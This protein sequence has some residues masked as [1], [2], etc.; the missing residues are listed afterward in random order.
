MRCQEIEEMLSAYANNE[1]TPDQQEAVETHLAGCADCRAKLEDYRQVRQQLE[2]L[3]TVPAAPDIKEIMLSRIKSA[4]H[5]E[6]SLKTWGRRALVLVP[7]AAVLAA[8]LVLQPWSSLNGIHSTLAK[9]HAAIESVQSYRFS[10]T[11]S[12]DIGG[13]TLKMEAEFMAPDSYHFKENADGTDMESTLIGDK[14]Y[15]K[16]DDVSLYALKS[17]INSFSSMISKDS[18]LKLLDV[19]TDIQ[20]LPDEVIGNVDCRHFKAKYDVEKMIRLQEESNAKMGIPPFNDEQRLQMYS[21]IEA[22]RIELWTGHTD[23]FIRQL[24]MDRQYLNNDGNLASTSLTSTY[25]DFNQPVTIEAP[26]DSTGNLLPGW[27]SV[28]PDQPALSKDIQSTI[29]NSDPA[30]RRI[31]YAVSLTNISGE[32][33]TALEIRVMPTFPDKDA[34]VGFR[35]T[36][37]PG[38]YVV[39]PGESN[40]YEITFSYNATGVGP[41]KIVNFIK[42][43]SLYISYRKSDGQQKMEL[44]HFEVPDSIY[45]LPTDLPSVRDLS[46]VGEYRIEEPGASSISQGVSGEIAGKNYLFVPV[47]TQDSGIPAGPGILV[48]DIQN[49]AKPVKVA[50]LRSPENT[51]YM[52]NSALSGT[53]LYAST[54]DFLWIIDVSDPESPRELSRFSEI[55]PLA[56]A[57]SGKYAYINDGN[58]KISTVDISDPSHPRVIGSLEFTSRSSLSLDISGGYLLAWAGDTLQTIDIS[59]PAALRIVNSYSFS[60]PTDLTDTSLRTSPAYARGTAIVGNYAYIALGGAGKVGMSV[61][62]I[63]DPANPFEIAFLG[64]QDRQMGGDLFVSGNRAYIFTRATMDIRQRLE[65]IDISNPAKPVESGFGR[66]PDYWTFFEK[67]SGGSYSNSYSSIGNYLYWFIG[68]PPNQPV[69]EIFNLSGS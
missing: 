27:T 1:L 22:Y 56:I 63:S 32:E 55:E 7:V 45:T 11:E 2:T 43:S 23:Y 25:Y 24:K 14:Q 10:F 51:W 58:R 68:N 37:D 31:D 28:T 33:L 47:N 48:L 69:I 9:V 16:G 49:P 67:V 59:S 57:I 19:L 66:L 12:D 65:F 46:P 5:P 40:N 18:T 39:K 8:L 36:G 50:Y 54:E 26:V 15:I 61:M 17:T 44:V 38:P 29:D 20:A 64:L 30:D 52:L 60:L 53:V 4:G 62:D 35:I 13:S 41:E 21:N 34:G 42:D 6:K 3:K